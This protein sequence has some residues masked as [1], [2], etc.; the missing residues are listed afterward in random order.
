MDLEVKGRDL[1]ALCKLY[2]QFRGWNRRRQG[3]I[4]NWISA[5]TR[6][7]I[8]PPHRSPRNLIFFYFPKFFPAALRIINPVFRRLRA[9]RSMQFLSA[10]YLF[11]KAESLLHNNIICSMECFG[12]NMTVFLRRFTT[13]MHSL[14]HNYLRQILYF[15]H[16]KTI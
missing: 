14:N 12:R 10:R 7:L 6:S 5:V 2:R 16:N 11:N 13:F 9:P 4:W 15:S 8:E 3:R 1:H